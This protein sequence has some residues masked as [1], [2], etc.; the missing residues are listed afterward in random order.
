MQSSLLSP[1][2]CREG[3]LSALE[4]KGACLEKNWPFTISK[5]QVLGVFF[6][7]AAHKC[8]RSDGLFRDV[9]SAGRAWENRIVFVRVKRWKENKHFVDANV[10]QKAPEKN[11]WSLGRFLT[12]QSD[13]LGQWVVGGI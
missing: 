13:L 11:R 9:G 2:K 12:N 8:R 4:M 3:A 5:A 7:M 1:F 6:H 10:C